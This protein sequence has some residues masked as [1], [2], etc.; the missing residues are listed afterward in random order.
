MYWTSAVYMAFWRQC[1]ILEVTASR[2][3][4]NVNRILSDSSADEDSTAPQP[5]HKKARPLQYDESQDSQET[6]PSLSQ[7]EIDPLKALQ[8]EFPN[9]S[10]EVSVVPVDAVVD[11]I[12][13]WYSINL[14]RYYKW[15]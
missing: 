7:P 9:F 14:F 12:R 1:F 3:R 4:K 5:T 2:K 10:T 15:P 11:A 6:L 8:E 13:P